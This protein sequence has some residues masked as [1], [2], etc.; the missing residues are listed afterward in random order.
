[1]DIIT[2][3]YDYIINNIEEDSPETFIMNYLNECSLTEQEKTEVL[4]LLAADYSI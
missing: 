3:T 4:N 1:M 2:E